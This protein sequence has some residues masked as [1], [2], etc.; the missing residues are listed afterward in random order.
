[1][2]DDI[3]ETYVNPCKATTSNQSAADHK[4]GSEER[5]LRKEFNSKNL[6]TY[7]KRSQT[8]GNLISALNEFDKCSTIGKSSM[9]GRQ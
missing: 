1:M 9:E 5:P 4:D 3:D 6:K 7:R 8:T 2:Q